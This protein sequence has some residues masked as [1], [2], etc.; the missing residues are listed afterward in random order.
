MV[1]NPS[2]TSN[3]AGTSSQYVHRTPLEEI[4]SL[5]QENLSLRRSLSAANAA[6]NAIVTQDT[7]GNRSDISQSQ[8][9]Q[10]MNMSLLP[11]GQANKTNSS[12]SGDGMA[13]NQVDAHKLNTRLKELFKERINS[14][15]EA[16]YLLTGYKVMQ[17]LGRMR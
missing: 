5:K 4:D 16:V 14:F 6:T 8:E 9:S 15:R 13:A 3:S 17:V 7:V 1:Y 2:V 11:I 12:G 10:D